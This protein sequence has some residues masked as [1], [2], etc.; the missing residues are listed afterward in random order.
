MRVDLFHRL[1]DAEN[2]KCAEHH[3]DI[4]AGSDAFHT[5]SRFAGNTTS[6]EQSFLTGGGFSG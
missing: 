2:P 3:A 4:V 1:V 5:Q 6:D